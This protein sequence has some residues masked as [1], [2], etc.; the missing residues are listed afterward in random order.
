M[1]KE[2]FFP[3]IIYAKDINLNTTHLSQIIFDWS[4]KDKGVKKTNV[5]GW[6]STP[7]MQTKQEYRS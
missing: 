1:I 3:T 6:H 2:K 7:D 4:K 5:N